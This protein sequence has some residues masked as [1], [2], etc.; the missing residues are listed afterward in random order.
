MRN[1]RLSP[2]HGLNPTIPKC[3]FCLEDKNEIILMGRID[4][5]REAPKNVAF[6]YEPCSKCKGFMKQG[7]MFIGVDEANTQVPRGWGQN[8]YRNGLFCVIKEDAVERMG[9]QP[10]ELRESIMKKRV[11]FTPRDAWDMLG[12]PTTNHPEQ[13]DDTDD[14]E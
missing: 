12:L 8:P 6:D 13:K 5:D 9:I 10:S 1:L 2:K 14:H 4:G 3:F 7:V 11:A